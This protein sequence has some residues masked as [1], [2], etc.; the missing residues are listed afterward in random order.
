MEE[1]ESDQP[2]WVNDTF[3]KVV[4]D[5]RSLHPFFDNQDPFKRLKGYFDLIINTLA[6][7]TNI[8]GLSFLF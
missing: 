8:S 7:E 3:S 4:D 6:V 1:K 2:R 5:C